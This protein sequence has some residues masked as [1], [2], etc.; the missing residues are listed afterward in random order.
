MYAPNHPYPT[1][2][3]SLL[4]VVPSKNNLAWS[5]DRARYITRKN[6]LNAF[7]LVEI[8]MCN[9]GHSVVTTL[10]VAYHMLQQ[11]YL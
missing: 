2:G 6:T 8:R 3:L 11:F 4:E 7:I 5:P 10:Y 1:V 9:G